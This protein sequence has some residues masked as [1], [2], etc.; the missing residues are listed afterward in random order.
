LAASWRVI[1]LSERILKLARATDEDPGVRAAAVR[2]LGSLGK[3]ETVGHL[4]QLAGMES[5]LRPAVVAALLELD[6]GEAAR[7]AAALLKTITEPKLLG[8]LL[9]AFAAREGVSSLLGAELEK[10]GIDPGQ[11]ERLRQAWIATGFVNAELGGAIDKLAGVVSPRMEFS[12]ELIAELVVAAKG[13]DRSRGEALFGSARAGCAA[14]HKVGEQGGVIGPDLTALGSGMLPDRIIT[15]VLWPAR[16]VKE[17]YSLT[18]VTKKDGQVLQGYLQASRDKER[19]FLR[20][21]ALAGMHE[22]PADQIEK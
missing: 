15:E 6:P 20:D 13:G 22:I 7:T 9:G 18:R 17:G 5:D 16:Q 3:E 10:V 4:R 2:A 19:V 1:E 21:F 8:E 12:D 14:C 11:G